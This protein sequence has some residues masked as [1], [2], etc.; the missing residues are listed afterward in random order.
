MMLT[1]GATPLCRGGGFALRNPEQCEVISCGGFHYGIKAPNIEGSG[2][3]YWGGAVG[4]LNRNFHF[5]VPGSV[6]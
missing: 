3:V 5:W 1:F 2:S 4:F 6:Q